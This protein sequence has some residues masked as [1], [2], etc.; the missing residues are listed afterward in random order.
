MIIGSTNTNINNAAY[1]GWT[2]SNYGHDELTA[3]QEQVASEQR[4]SVLD[5]NFKKMVRRRRRTAMLVASLITV[6]VLL[7]PSTV[8]ADTL[9]PATGKQL[10]YVAHCVNAVNDISKNGFGAT[11]SS[12][13]GCDPTL[14]T[15]YF[16]CQPLVKKLYEWCDNV[17]INTNININVNINVDSSQCSL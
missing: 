11:K 4:Y 13:M 5:N 15:C 8:Q 17:N 16:N 12:C 7:T 10:N 9:D 2:R 3:N 6:L 14:P 1:C